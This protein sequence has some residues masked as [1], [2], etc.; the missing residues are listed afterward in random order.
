[1]TSTRTAPRPSAPRADV[2][3]FDD[4]VVR[5]II[6]QAVGVSFGPSYGLVAN[7]LLPDLSDDVTD[8]TVRCGRA[9]AGC[10]AVGPAG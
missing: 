8:G 7:G 6:G 5:V 10:A 1:M 3:D 4:A 2:D 9:A